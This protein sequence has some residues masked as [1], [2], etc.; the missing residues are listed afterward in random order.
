MIWAETQILVLGSCISTRL[1][2]SHVDRI[3]CVRFSN[4]SQEQVDVR[5]RHLIAW[6][7][8]RGERQSRPEQHGPSL[9]FSNRPWTRRRALRTSLFRTMQ[10]WAA[11]FC[12]FD[13]AHRPLNQIL[14][15]CNTNGAWPLGSVCRMSK[16]PRS[17]RRATAPVNL[18][19]LRNTG[20]L[21]ITLGAWPRLAGPKD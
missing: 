8:I 6:S 13:K 10:V 11:R 7:E 5:S 21:V 18:V 16:H 20:I 12:S 9:L 3:V 14:R 1:C 19:K 2:D 4:S 17:R 15:A